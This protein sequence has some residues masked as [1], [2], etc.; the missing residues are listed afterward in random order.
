MMNGRIRFIRQRDQQAG[1]G[2]GFM[3]ATIRILIG[4]FLII[5]TTGC[6]KRLDP[7]EQDKTIQN[8]L[9]D[10]GIDGAWLE[11]R[12]NMSGEWDRVALIYGYVDD[13][14]ACEEIQYMYLVK[15]PALQYRCVPELG[16]KD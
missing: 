2:G 3:Q 4:I 14:E 8:L 12:S 7:A 5:G 13:Y 10:K 11:K 9:R 1:I 15:Y 6:A 16:K